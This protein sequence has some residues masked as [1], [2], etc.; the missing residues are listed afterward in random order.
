M[1]HLF[2]RTARTDAFWR[3][4]SDRT[5][6]A[7]DYEVVAFGNSPRMADELAA[8]VVDGPKRATAGLLRDFTAN[9]EAMPEVGGHVVLVDGSGVPC[10]VW[11]TTEVRIGPLSS[12]DER[13]AWDEGEG[14]RTR[15][16]WL[17][18]HRA[19]FTAQAEAEGFAFHDGIETVFE[20]FEVVWPIMDGAAD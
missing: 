4:F 18:M 11:R 7:G 2:E 16:D 13:F 6:Y 9:G 8:L 1:E 20:R 14:D 10:A 15:A 19:F 12:V 3:E 17:R 5:G